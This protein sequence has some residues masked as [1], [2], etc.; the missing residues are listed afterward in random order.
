M[1]GL[2]QILTPVTSLH[3]FSTPDRIYII[4]FVLGFTPS[5]QAVLC[6]YDFISVRVLD[7][8][9]C[10]HLVSWRSVNC[11]QGN[12]RALQE[13][14][15]GKRGSAWCLVSDPLLRW[16]GVAWTGFRNVTSNPYE[17]KQPIGALSANLTTR[18]P[19]TR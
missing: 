1:L 4:H 17:A 3:V 13:S 16:I 2:D 10:Q 8:L 18:L 12:C 15:V 19:S 9:A 6:C 14:L 11:S 7:S 5:P